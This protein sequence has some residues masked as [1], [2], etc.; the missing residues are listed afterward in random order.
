MNRCNKGDYKNDDDEAK[1]LN[2]DFI[3]LR[4]VLLVLSL[5]PP[6]ITEQKIF[7]ILQTV[8]LFTVHICYFAVPNGKYM[9][10]ANIVSP[11]KSNDNRF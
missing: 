6:L 9:S 2:N 7:N 5:L 8:H 3:Y 1:K 11:M 4:F 10:L